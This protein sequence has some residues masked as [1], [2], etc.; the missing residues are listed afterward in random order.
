MSQ[1]SAVL[2]LL[3]ILGAGAAVIGGGVAALL[4][5]TVDDTPAAEQA[6]T[7]AADV[8]LT[9]CGENLHQMTAGVRIT[10]GSS[11]VSSYF[12]D[13]EFVGGAAP[14]VVETVP[15]VLEG[16]RPGRSRRIPVGSTRPAPAR[17]DCRI[18]DVDRLQT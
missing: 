9:R 6:A 11:S 8:T 17:F 14:H 1:L 5:L 13:L 15:V 7:E 12:V 2:G 18:G 3:V 16:L 4:A 10:N